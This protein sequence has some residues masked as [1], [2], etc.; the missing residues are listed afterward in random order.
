MYGINGNPT[1]G[2]TEAWGA[3]IVAANSDTG[4]QIQGGHATDD[5]Y[6][7]GWS[8]NGSSYTN[9]RR[10]LHNGNLSSFIT[11]ALIDALNVKAFGILVT[12]S[13][14]NNFYPVVWH[15]NGERLYDTSN[16]TFNPSSGE[17]RSEYYRAIGLG[18]NTAPASNDGLFSGYGF[19]G[20]RDAVYISNAAGAVVLNHGGLHGQLPKLATTSAGVYVT[21]TVNA[22]STMTGTDAIATSDI[23][24]KRNLQPILGAAQKLRTVRTTT[25]ERIDHEMVNGLYPRKGSVIAQDFLRIF[26]ESITYTDDAKLGKKLNVSVPATV[27]MTIAAVNEHTDTIA[28]QAK[29]IESLNQR[30]ERLEKLVEGL[31]PN[32]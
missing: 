9:W 2:T 26:P 11:K 17:L 4:L 22:S 25:H 29:T 30:I 12:P 14:A 10:I 18:L 3:M 8:N 19:L 24:V 32:G 7:R 28:A 6:F 21:G 20:N 5:L 27:V 16:F 1:N 23:R 31:I 13:V 15:D